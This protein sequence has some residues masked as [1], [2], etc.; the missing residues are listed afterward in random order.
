MK[1]HYPP[2]PRDWFFGVTIG[3][4]SL[5]EPLPFL[6]DMA[7]RYGDVAYFHVGPLHTFLGALQG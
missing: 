5:R 4:R 3:L 1:T 7:R 2:G 6:Q